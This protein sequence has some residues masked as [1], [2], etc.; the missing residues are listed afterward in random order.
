MLEGLAMANAARR[1]ATLTMVGALPEQISFCESRA[2]ELGLGDAF[3]IIGRV[4][5]SAIPALLA[6]ADAG[7]CIWEDRLYW[8][9]NPPTKLFEYL[10]AG[11]PVLVSNIRTHTDYVRDWENGVVF[12]YAATSFAQCIKELWERRAE[13]PRMRAR[14]L[15]ESDKYLWSR[16][17]EQ[18]LAAL[19]VKPMETQA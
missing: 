15:A 18:F 19:P 11:L 6:D 1:V 7:I 4:P 3:R 8:R 10:V 12:D 16:L 17:E 2:K 5:G 13:L 9:F 14:A